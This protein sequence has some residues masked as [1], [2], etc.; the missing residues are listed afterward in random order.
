MSRPA[1]TIDEACRM[2]SVFGL[3]AR[4]SK[5]DAPAAQ[6]IPQVALELADHLALLQLVHLDDGVQQLEVVAGVARDLLE[7]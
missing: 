1:S 2:S 4:P 6:L 5:R 7:G 3:K